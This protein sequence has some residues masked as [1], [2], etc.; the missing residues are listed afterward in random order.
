L[1][2]GNTKKSYTTPKEE[3]TPR[4]LAKNVATVKKN[5]TRIKARLA[6]IAG[7]PVSERK[8]KPVAN[9]V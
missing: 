4:D 1:Y 8:D 5:A 2:E 9:P 6:K 7:K 3:R